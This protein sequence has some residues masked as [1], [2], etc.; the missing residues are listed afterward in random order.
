MLLEMTAEG[1]LLADFCRMMAV[2][3]TRVW[4]HMQV[5]KE[6]KRRYNEARELGFAKIG[7]DAL[8][9]ADDKLMDTDRDAVQRAK[10]QVETRMKLLACLAPHIY[11]Q[12]VAIG[13]AA[14]LPP[15]QVTAVEREERIKKLLTKV[16]PTTIDNGSSPLLGSP[17]EDHAEEDP[18]KEESPE[19]K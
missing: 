9:I 4:Q 15:I 2:T 18:P 6:D 12:K 3:R 11:G 5:N 7:E 14:D 10:L 8:A 13:G 17:N 1:T 16:L 19:P